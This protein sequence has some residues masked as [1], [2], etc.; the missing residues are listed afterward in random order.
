MTLGAAVVRTRSDSNIR[1]ISSLRNALMVDDTIM[2]PNS[3]I[4][5]AG[6]SYSAL[7]R[8]AR[9]WL[10]Q[11]AVFLMCWHWTAFSCVSF[12]HSSQ[13]WRAWIVSKIG[14][15]DLGSFRLTILE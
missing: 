14:S 3:R 6:S 5:S 7:N 9:R 8:C 4:A 1:T 12:M 13:I 2:P 15:P 10:I 11:C